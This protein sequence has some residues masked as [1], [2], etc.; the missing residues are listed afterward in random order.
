MSVFV[1]ITSSL[2]RRLTVSVPADQIEKAMQPRLAKLAKTAKLPGFRA[3]KIPAGVIAKQYGAAVRGETIEELL[4]SS[5]R[6]ALQQENLQPA[7]MPV[8][9]SLKADPGM[10]LEY[11]VTFEIYPE[12]Q[13]K[14]LAGVTIE[15]L[16]VPIEEA[17]VDR[18]L[19]QMRV[20][21]QATAIDEAFAKKLGIPDGDL[22][23]LRD[24]VRKHM[25]QQLEG[26]VKNNQKNQIIDALLKHHTLEIPKTMV[27]EELQH[28]EQALLK[29]IKQQN[30]AM[31]K[32]ALPA[33]EH[34]KLVQTA[35]RRVALGL[36]FSTLIK[37][38]NIKADPAR[39]K[40]YLERMF[41][42]FEHAEKMLPS[43]LKDQAFMAQIRSQILEEQV[44]EHLLGQV[45]FVD[46]NMPYTEALEASKTAYIDPDHSM[47]HVHSHE[48]HDHDHDHAHCG[49]D[50]SHDH[51]DHSHS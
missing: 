48:H 44:V 23:K 1:E 38:N 28:M 42:A 16:I 13:L 3:G 30:P 26:F 21:H 34:A 46:K 22:A 31:A 43:L 8:I 39:M 12:V 18:V 5:L 7:A 37:E 32:P 41:G 11:S 35:E 10:P 47:E 6:A 4:D 49:H 50:H 40:V 15:K 25:T 51:D 27:N 19:E 20:Q 14:S 36:L 9:Q 33:G 24:E 45:Q 2:G 29:K 17:D